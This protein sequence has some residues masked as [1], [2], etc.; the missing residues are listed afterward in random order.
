MA[1]RWRHAKPPGCRPEVK[2]VRY[3]NERSEVSKVAAAHSGSFQYQNRQY[4]NRPSSVEQESSPDFRP[5]ISA[6][7]SL[8]IDC[9]S[10]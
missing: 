1:R 7:R 4:Q 2:L 10:S 9:S 5:R 6:S 8:A 3:S